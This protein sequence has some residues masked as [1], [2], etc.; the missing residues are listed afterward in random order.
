[1]LHHLPSNHLRIEPEGLTA[2]GEGRRLPRKQHEIGHR[3]RLHVDARGDAARQPA[4]KHLGGLIDIARV[5]QKMR[6]R[7]VIFRIVAP[8][9]RARQ[10]PDQPIDAVGIFLQPG[11]AESAIVNGILSLIDTARDAR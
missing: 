11:C 8:D 10:R 4:Q 5:G 7:F 1:M 3:Q 6:E 9:R 2:P